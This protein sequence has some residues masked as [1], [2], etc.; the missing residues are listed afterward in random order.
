MSGIAKRR[1]RT[2]EDAKSEIL[3]V[4]Q[5]LL[6]EGGPDA[7]RVQAV[8]RELGLSDAA[9]HYHF[10]SRDALMEALLRDVAR[11]MKRELR[12]AIDTWDAERFDVGSL[13]TLLDETYRGRGYGRLAGWMNLMGW[14]SKGSGMFRTHA[15]AIHAARLD[16]A[17]QSD[18]TAP[19]MEDSLHLVV[20]LNLVIWADAVVGDEW[21]RSVGLPATGKSGA[22][23]REWFA[24]LLEQHLDDG[25]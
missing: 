6:R 23:F 13:V 18:A 17:R 10:G 15:E 9:V 7:V 4:A 11:R 20:L 25:R 2:V 19:P 14:R 1:R 24:S 3:A 8:A 16:R 22:A 12:D 5:R 21:R